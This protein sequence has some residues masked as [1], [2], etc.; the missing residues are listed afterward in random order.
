MKYFHFFSVVCLVLVSYVNASP[1][2]VSDTTTMENASADS[3]KTG[4][5]FAKGSDISWLSEMEASGYPFFNK[6]GIR[7]DI[8]LTLKEQGMNAVRLRVWVNPADGWNGLP[9]VLAKAQRAKQAGM[10]IMIDFHYSDT[11]ADPGHQTKPAAWKKHS[12]A[13]LRTDIAQHTSAT[14][15][16]LRDAGITPEW[17]QV[18]N[19]T[20]DGMLWDSARPSKSASNM[21]NYAGLTTAAYDA[22]KQVFPATLVIVHLANCHNNEGFRWIFDGLK[23]NG[24]KFDVIGASSYPLEA[25]GHTWQ[26]ANN[27]CLANLNDMTDRYQVPVM[28]T[29]VGAPWDHPQAK[30]ILNDVIAKVR[31]VSQNRGLGVMYWEAQSYKNWKGYTFGAFDNTGKP[32]QA[33]DAFLN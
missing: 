8:F 9:D 26:S 16:A 32:T 4:K 3:V 11:W 33:L 29:E 27:A 14:L 25:T 30:A 12:I 7:Q 21:K 23:N 20:N 6:A 31:S 28:V 2:N 1:Q 10:R 19:E 17:V 13:E 5:N 18:G 15:L 22:V 24:G